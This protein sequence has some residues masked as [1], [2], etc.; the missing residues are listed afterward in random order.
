MTRFVEPGRRTVTGGSSENRGL[1]R[2][3]RNG[4]SLA[5]LAL[6]LPVLLLTVLFAIG[7]LPGWIAHWKEMLEDTTTKIGRPRQI[8]MGPTQRKYVPIDQRGK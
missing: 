6:V 3:A 7:R 1:F 8:Y 5:E 2:H 4:Q